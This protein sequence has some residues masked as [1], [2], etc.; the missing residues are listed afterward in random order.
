MGRPGELDI[1]NDEVLPSS[2]F[3]AHDCIKNGLAETYI[4]RLA[5]CNLG[6]NRWL[7]GPR[8]SVSVCRLKIKRSWN[9]LPIGT[10]SILRLSGIRE[11]YQDAFALPAGLCARAHRLIC[12]YLSHS[13][14]GPKVGSAIV[15]ASASPSRTLVSR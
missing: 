5:E 10:G 13:S 2:L 14:L 3:L 1:V 7:S 12:S 15:R 4:H 8:V 6:H 11:Y 9:E